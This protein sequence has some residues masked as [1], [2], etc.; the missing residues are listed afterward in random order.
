MTDAELF[1][2]APAYKTVEDL[3]VELTVERR[4]GPFQFPD[5][6]QVGWGGKWY[7]DKPRRA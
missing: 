3:V 1:A 7:E 6:P 5:Y 4:E 2:K